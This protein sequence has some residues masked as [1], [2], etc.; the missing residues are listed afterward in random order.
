VWSPDEVGLA[1][2]FVSGD[3]DLDG[4]LFPVLGALEGSVKR[5]RRLGPAA[6]ARAISVTLRLGV[7]PLPPPRPAE[8]LRLAGWRHSKRRDAAAIPI[9]TT[10]AMTSTGSCSVRR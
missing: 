8:K 3:I 1:R 2:A 9:T 5:A 7:L 10:S 6:V 4:D